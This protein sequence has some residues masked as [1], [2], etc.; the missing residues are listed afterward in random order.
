M[1]QVELLTS[2]LI[3]I[4][5]DDDCLAD[6]IKAMNH[7]TTGVEERIFIDGTSGGGGSEDDGRFP[8]C[9]HSSKGHNTAVTVV[10]K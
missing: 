3:Y 4:G 5:F 8:E 6:Y 9:S 2:P 1:N 10:C 7:V